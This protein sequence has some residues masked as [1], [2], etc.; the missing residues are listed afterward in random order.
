MHSS[1]NGLQRRIS[2]FDQL[3]FPD[4]DDNILEQAENTEGQHTKRQRQ[5]T[6]NKN[7]K[8]NKQSKSLDLQSKRIRTKRVNSEN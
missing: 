8:S 3:Q 7:K 6:W 4:Q 2:T 1:L 5:V